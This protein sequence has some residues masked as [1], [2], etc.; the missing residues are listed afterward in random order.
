[1]PLLADQRL[2]FIHIPKN[3]GKSI[4]EYFLGP[5]GPSMGTRTFANRAAKYLLN[6]T[7]NE[8]AKRN[9]LGSYD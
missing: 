6:K 8:K 5:H 7:T 3:A 1:M 4:E 2:I 9:L